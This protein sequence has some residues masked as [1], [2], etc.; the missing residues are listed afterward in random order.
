MEL[1]IFNEDFEDNITTHRMK[2]IAL[3]IKNHHRYHVVNWLLN[4]KS[5]STGIYQSIVYNMIPWLEFPPDVEKHLI[6][7]LLGEKEEF[8]IS[9]ERIFTEEL[10]DMVY[11][12]LVEEHLDAWFK[13]YVVPEDL[14]PEELVYHN[15]YVEFAK[16]NGMM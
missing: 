14:S 6:V 1:F 5:P 9:C 12:F 11:K 8:I 7:V 3:Q 4:N 16:K 2:R 10:S 13:G 15:E